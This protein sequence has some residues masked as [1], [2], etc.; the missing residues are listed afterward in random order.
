MGDTPQAVAGLADNDIRQSGYGY[1]GELIRTPFGAVCPTSLPIQVRCAPCFIS[2]SGT[3]NA[4]IPAG[5]R[6]IDLSNGRYPLMTCLSAA[7]RSDAPQAR[8]LGW[9][10]AIL[11]KSAVGLVNP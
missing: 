8:H 3:V 7:R 2:Q 6:E 4:D 9:T 11:P 1:R 5:N 10:T